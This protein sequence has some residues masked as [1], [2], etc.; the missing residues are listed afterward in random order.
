MRVD[1]I[2]FTFPVRN[3]DFHVLDSWSA[4]GFGRPFCCLGR[5]RR[6][7]RILKQ[8]ESLA[9][10]L[11]VAFK[12]NDGQG[13][14]GGGVRRVGHGMA[15]AIELF[16]NATSIPGV[17]RLLSVGGEQKSV[18]KSI[19]RGPRPGELE[20]LRSACSLSSRSV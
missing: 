4:G 11:R 9:G 8:N 6:L 16:S 5:R 15:G 13:Q 2:F 14:L 1:R 12:V 18:K 3:D 10:S 17:A 19:R 20:W 7:T